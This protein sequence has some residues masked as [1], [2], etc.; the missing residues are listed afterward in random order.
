M[1]EMKGAGTSV[2]ETKDK[3]GEEEELS[4]SRGG[5]KK[6]EEKVDDGGEGAEQGCLLLLLQEVCGLKG[7]GRTRRES[8][9]KRGRRFVGRRRWRSN[10][11]EVSKR[12][13]R[14]RW[15]SRMLLISSSVV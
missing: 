15:M 6:D 7:P 12:R 4:G 13:R 5:E 8:R 2:V 9:W 11:V 10:L 3:G 1:M 14:R